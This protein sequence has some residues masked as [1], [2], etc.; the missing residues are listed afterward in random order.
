MKIIFA[1]SQYSLDI[2]QDNQDLDNLI[3]TVSNFGEHINLSDVFT[4]LWSKLDSK[5]DQ[6]DQIDLVIDSKAGFTNTRVIAIWGRSWSMF[7]QKPFCTYQNGELITQIMYSAEP[8]I[9]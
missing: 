3:Q 9:G 1:L 8:R 2:Y 5:I 7:T 4:N 6:A